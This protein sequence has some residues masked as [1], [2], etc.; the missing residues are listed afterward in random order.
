M[1]EIAKMWARKRLKDL[2]A[3]RDRAE[4][5][6]IITEMKEAQAEAAPIIHKAWLDREA[7][8]RQD[9]PFGFVMVRK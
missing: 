3:R 4:L 6:R 5:A 9:G 1:D 8:M 2:Q 7:R